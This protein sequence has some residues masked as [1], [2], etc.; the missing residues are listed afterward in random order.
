[1]DAAFPDKIQQHGFSRVNLRPLVAPAE[2]LSLPECHAIVQRSAVEFRGWAFPHSQRRTDEHGGPEN[3]GDYVQHWC[4]WHY[5]IEFWRMYRSTQFLHYKVLRED[6]KD[7]QG[8][9]ETPFISIDWSI[10][11]ITEVVEFAARLQ[12]SGIYQ[13]GLRIDISLNNIA[14][15]HLWVGPRRMDF[16]YPRVNHADSIKLVREVAET[17]LQEISLEVSRNMILE[18]FDNFGW[19]PFGHLEKPPPFGIFVIQSGVGDFHWV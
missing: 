9:P 7:V 15:R 16:S 3:V 19:Q 10:H 12:R 14:G 13:T 11:L 17:A 18:F 5:H 2:K 4:D 8:A 6:T 1:M